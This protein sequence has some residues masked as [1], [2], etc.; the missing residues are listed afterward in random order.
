[1]ESLITGYYPTTD[2]YDVAGACAALGGISRATLDR[3][4][5][6]ETPGRR[7]LDAP[8]VAGQ[9]RIAGALVRQ[10]APLPAGADQQA[11]ES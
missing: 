6:P 7:R 3:W 5:P 8:G 1:M 9:V 10:H 2:E 11:G 4:I